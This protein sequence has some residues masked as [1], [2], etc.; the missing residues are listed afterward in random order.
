MIAN[1]AAERTQEIKCICRHVYMYTVQYMIFNIAMS[2]IS[3]KV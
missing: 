1:S 3:K 2:L